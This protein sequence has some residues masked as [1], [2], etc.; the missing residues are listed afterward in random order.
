MKSVVIAASSMAVLFVL[1]TGQVAADQ[2]GMA[3]MHDQYVFKGRRCFT[4]HTHVGT[5]SPFRS[6]RKAVSSAAQD[7]S[8]F[9]A[10][11]YGSSWARW[12]VAVGKTVAC[13]QSSQ[14]WTCE[15]QARPCLMQRGRRARHAKR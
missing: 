14:G 15:V 8:S 2:S 11:E 9:T 6:K 5:G 1:G 4:G 13:E 10:F 7:W 12:R 3:G